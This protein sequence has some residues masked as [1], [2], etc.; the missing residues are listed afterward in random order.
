MEILGL[1]YMGVG[2]SDLSDWTK[3][4]TDW[5]GM[6]MIERGNIYTA[7]RFIKND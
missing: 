7:C 3:F 5:L 1:G 2:A 4:A 6:Q